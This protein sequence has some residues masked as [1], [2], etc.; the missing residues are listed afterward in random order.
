[1]KI[2]NRDAFLALEGSVLFSEVVLVDEGERLVFELKPHTDPLMIRDGQSIQG[3]YYEAAVAQF[4]LR[5]LIAYREEDVWKSF[6]EDID[7]T[8]SRG[9][10]DNE[11][12]LVYEKSDVKEIIAKLMECI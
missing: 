6:I 3:S 10:H 5:H 7:L 1:M 11:Y 2:I 9:S 4:S 8:A 12:Y